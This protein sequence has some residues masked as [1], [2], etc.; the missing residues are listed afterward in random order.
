MLAII[1]AI[2]EAIAGLG[3]VWTVFDVGRL[4][5]IEG[6]AVVK[7][8]SVSADASALS[9]DTIWATIVLALDNPSLFTVTLVSYSSWWAVVKSNLKFYHACWR[10]GASSI[11]EYWI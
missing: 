7:I 4:S 9:W 11:F 3:V 8:C 5:E 1:L 10:R 6:G 2:R